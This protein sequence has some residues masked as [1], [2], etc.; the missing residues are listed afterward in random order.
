[1]VHPCP[2]AAALRL[3]PGARLRRGG[4]VTLE[5]LLVMPVL[6]MTL[7]AVVQFGVFFSN[8]QQLALATRVGAEVASQSVL[9]NNA[10]Y[11]V[12][13]FTVGDPVP[14]DIV[15]AITT[16]LASSGITPCEILLDHNAN[17]F[18]FPPASGIFITPNQRF[19]TT[20]SVC[21]CE[22]P[23]LASLPTIR[24]TV[25]VTVCVPMTQMMPNCLSA[26]G[27]DLSN[28]SAQS[29]TVL[30]YEL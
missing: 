29:T 28:C 30:R 14:T 1:M 9:P 2:A 12:A 20:L 22:P 11:G 27:F 15:N 16:Q 21:H 13:P 4:A 8:M 24:R 10:V 3:R 23:A 6:V 7:L 18:E 17:T 25:R 19:T 26:F 5:L